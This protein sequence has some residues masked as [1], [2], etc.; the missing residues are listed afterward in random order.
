MRK[1][2]NIFIVLLLLPFIGKAAGNADTIRLYRLD[3]LRLYEPVYD[4]V[5]VADMERKPV[6]I[7]ALSQ[8]KFVNYY[9]RMYTPVPLRLM[10]RTMVTRV[11]VK[12]PENRI[13][14]VFFFPGYYYRNMRLFKAKADNPSGTITEIRDS[15][16][17]PKT[18]PAGC[19]LK[20]QP[21][22]EAVFYLSFDFIRTNANSFSSQLIE[23]DFLAHWQR[24]TRYW[25]P[26][27]DILTY[28][29]SGILLL[30]IF[31]SI[32]AY[33]Q[34]RNSEFI[35]YSIYAACS[36][37][38]FFLKSYALGSFTSLNFYYEEYLDFI[39]MGLG[40]IFYLFFMRRFLDAGKEH[41]WLDRFLY[42][43]SLVLGGMLVI[44][45]AAFFLTP[46]YILIYYL[47]NLVIKVLMLIVGV[48]FIIYG[49]RHPKRDRL[50]NYLVI[51]NL[52]L[53]IFS[54]LSLL[55][56]TDFKLI[57][58][59]P[60]S[61]LNRGLILYE[62]GVVLELA[63][64]LTGLAYKNRRDL[65]EKILEQERLK[66][67]NERKEFEKQMA[68]VTTRQEERDRI[69]AD[70]HDELGSGMTAIRLMSEI[71][72]TRMRDGAFPELEKISNQANDLLGKMNSIIWT[73][74]SSNDSLESLVAYVR[75][76][77]LEY[78]ENTEVNCRVR[79][80]EHLPEV[81]MSG[82]KR[83]NIF[84][85]VKEALNNLLKHAH[86]TEVGIDLWLDNNRLYIRVADNGIG[87][88]EEK[89]R[90]FGNGLSNMRRRMESIQ[91]EFLVQSGPGT[92]LTF[93]APL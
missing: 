11:R 27:S 24:N 57:Y 35:F 89:L 47:E 71:M 55:T 29:I 63:F 46:G 74:K 69:S 84:L 85:S 82:E 1:L 58:W 42:Y 43:S 20:L 36:A 80:P 77:S 81:E 45:T 64:F 41:P 76:H 37:I 70:M 15:F 38:L 28:V 3:T 5:Q 79:V 93:I 52:A 75:S 61:I 56:F 73:M 91:G 67:D 22:E 21:G 92:T 72:K 7:A 19:L 32:A 68:I 17:Q 33:F 18:F 51:G 62:F 48:I 50:M 31:Y 12:N 14:E 54:V 2:R 9:Y 78:F 88:N 4:Y 23:K 10:E 44:F 86:A 87:I 83:R 65:T 30:M 49:I 13:R 59:N 60:K 26:D 90:R 25:S 39:I 6:T 16:P 66:L 8:L 40:V 34:N 53:L